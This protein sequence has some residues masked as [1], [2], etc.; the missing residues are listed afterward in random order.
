[1][2]MEENIVCIARIVPLSCFAIDY[3]AAVPYFEFH[4]DTCGIPSS[5]DRRSNV[6]QLDFFFRHILF[7]D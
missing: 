2:V 5:C 1:M 3:D 4:T 7:V 6:I